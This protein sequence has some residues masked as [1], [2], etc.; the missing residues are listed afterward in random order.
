MKVVD[1]L[2]SPRQWTQEVY[3]KDVKGKRVP[4]TSGKAECWCT[5]GLVYHC[6]GKEIDM[7]LPSNQPRLMA[8]IIIKK[9][10]EHLGVESLTDWNDDPKRKFRDVIGLFRT[11]NV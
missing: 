2:T 7:S 11:L 8:D 6:Y 5:E 10:K 4:P 1:F 3:A 9:I